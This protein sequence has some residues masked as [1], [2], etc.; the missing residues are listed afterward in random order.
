MNFSHLPTSRLFPQQITLFPPKLGIKMGSSLIL[1]RMEDTNVS[2]LYWREIEVGD[3]LLQVM[4]IFF[5]GPVWLDWAIVSC[6]EESGKEGFRRIPSNKIKAKTKKI[7]YFK[8]EF[9]GFFFSS[10]HSI[11]C[12]SD[13][14]ILYTDTQHLKKKGAYFRW[15]FQKNT[16]L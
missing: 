8:N 9:V 1:N 13:V 4:C 14:T 2:K 7:F 5:P 12:H 11:H 15:A 3:L 6:P 10:L 16:V